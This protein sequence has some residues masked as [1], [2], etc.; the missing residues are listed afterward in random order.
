MDEET[1]TTP[2]A[3]PDAATASRAATPGA[4]SSGG[5][6]AD[7]GAQ[8]GGDPSAVY[9]NMYGA[10]GGGADAATTYNTAAT[11]DGTGGASPGRNDGTDGSSAGGPPDTDPSFWDQL[12]HWWYGDPKAPAEPE[13]PGNPF[14]CPDKDSPTKDPQNC[15]PGAGKATPQDPNYMS[16][17][18]R[19][20]F[21]RN[22]PIGAVPA[23]V[24]MA[25]GQDEKSAIQRANQNMKV[26]QPFVDAGQSF[27]PP[28]YP[29]AVDGDS[30]GEVATGPRNGGTHL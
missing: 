26:A 5:G 15:G 11:D 29:S 7:S 2:A 9:A 28:V 14:L 3:P 13:D 4:D 22:N 20:E 17:I 25:T 10:D 8:G 6:P 12:K 18:E 27:T 16:P 30:T 24:G 19:A 21:L 1:A 23:S